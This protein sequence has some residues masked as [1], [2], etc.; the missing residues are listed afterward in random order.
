MDSL[1]T[2][3][4]LKVVYQLPK[5]SKLWAVIQ[6]D[7]LLPQVVL[8]NLTLIDIEFDRDLD[9][10]PGFRE[11]LLG[12]LESVYF[13]SERWQ[14]GDFLGEFEKA[15]H[16]TPA[17]NTLSAF[18]FYPFHPWNPN[19]SSLLSFKQLQTLE[20]G[21]TCY[22]GSCSSRVDDDVIT[23]LAQAMP[24]LKVL[25]LGGM[26]CE[27]STGATVNGLIN[28]VTRCPHLSQLRIHF[29]VDSLVDAATTPSDDG[30]VL[31]QE[32]CALMDLGVGDIPIPP[33][34]ET[35]VTFA[36]FKFS[37]HPQHYRLI[38]QFRVENCRRKRQVQ[39]GS[40]CLRVLRR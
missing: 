36:Y 20:I 22:R 2:E 26:P 15:A 29:R 40:T 38:S 8:P 25:K 16:A 9:W 4:A 12:Q 37:S 1:L 23:N 11:V 32:G 39:T 17:Q 33:Q 6:G 24:K 35:M 31:Q 34:S 7:T 28:L 21:L 19:Y 5:L 18:A 10:L 14:N 30:R 3:E 27:A 13:C